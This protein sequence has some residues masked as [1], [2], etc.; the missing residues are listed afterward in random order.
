MTTKLEES[1]NPGRLSDSFSANNTDIKVKLI[2]SFVLLFLV[3]FLL[4]QK[5]QLT[6]VYLLLLKLNI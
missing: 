2:L 3:I 1:P 5:L 6:I 4:T